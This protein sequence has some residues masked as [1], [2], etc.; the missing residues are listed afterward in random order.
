MFYSNICL[1]VRRAVAPAIIGCCI[2]A[3]GLLAFAVDDPPRQ[4]RR[5]ARDLSRQVQRATYLAK[6]KG[7]SDREMLAAIS[8]KPDLLLAIER[9]RGVELK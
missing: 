5:E 7:M 8:H 9:Q 4:T 2:L 3:S 6:V 1:M